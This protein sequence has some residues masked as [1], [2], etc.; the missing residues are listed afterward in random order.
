MYNP[1]EISAIIKQS[2]Q[3]KNITV[4]KMLEDCQINKGFIYDLEHKKTYPSCD[5]I[6][7]IADCLDCS[8]DF[9]LGK[10]DNPEIN[11]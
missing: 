9:L 7:R 10:T 1:H 4:K 11:K 2:A 8:V 5:K 6:S 3:L